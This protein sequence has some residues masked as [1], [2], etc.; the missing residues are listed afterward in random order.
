M[1]KIYLLFVLFLSYF[2]SYGQ[3]PIQEAYVTKTLTVVDEEWQ[4]VTFSKM[5]KIASNKK[6]QLKIDNAEFLT[7]FSGE[8]KVAVV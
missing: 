7:L 1:K 3:E 2:L 8:L 4:E 5:I 6:G